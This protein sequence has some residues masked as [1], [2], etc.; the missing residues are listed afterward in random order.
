MCWDGE[1][2]FS[3]A[4]AFVSMNNS[5]APHTSLH[6]SIRQGCPLVLYFYVLTIDALGYL[7]EDAWLQGHI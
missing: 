6:R 4:S 2:S 7:L 3:S 5:L 1:H